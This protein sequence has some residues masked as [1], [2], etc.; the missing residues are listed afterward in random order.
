[1]H[2][3]GPWRAGRYGSVVTDQYVGLDVTPSIQHYY[4]G[5]PICESA[6]AHNQQLIQCAPELLEFVSE[7]LTTYPEHP[8]A[9]WASRL[10]ARAA[11]MRR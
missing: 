10:I 5:N 1:M 11:G 7:F 6:N 8:W 9:E 4:G 2:T 3:P